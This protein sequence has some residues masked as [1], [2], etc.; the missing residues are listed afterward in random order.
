MDAS[1]SPIREALKSAYEILGAGAVACYA[2]GCSNPKFSFPTCTYQCLNE[3]GVVQQLQKY[4]LS[5]YLF[6]F[7]FHFKFQCDLN[8]ISLFWI[9]KL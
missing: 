8:F 3:Q 4:Q 5:P 1:Y 9:M 6:E 7:Q 2:A